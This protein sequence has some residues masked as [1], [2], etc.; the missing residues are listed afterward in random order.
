MLEDIQ[1]KIHALTLTLCATLGLEVVETTVHGHKNDVTIQIL[2]DKSLGGI[3]IQECSALNRLIVETIDKEAILNEDGY[4][5]EVS[6]P[7]LDRPLTTY[8]DFLRNLNSEVKLWLN[9]SVE[10][11]K[12]H[13]GILMGATP[14]AITI[15]TKH[16]Q[17]VIVSLGQV[18]KGL[19]II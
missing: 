17:Q 8:K 14:Q 1:K 15:Y 6:S 3:T 4:S 10:G 2:V 11:K 18:I 5:L 9:E 13:S 7:G 12:E 16:K 19:L